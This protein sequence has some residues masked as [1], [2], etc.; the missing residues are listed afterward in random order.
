MAAEL[1]S[2]L[3]DTRRNLFLVGFTILVL[4]LVV[5][6][7][8]TFSIIR[9]SQLNGGSQTLGDATWKID[10]VV[11][12]PKQDG[13]FTLTVQSSIGN[14]RRYAGVKS[15]G[16][17]NDGLTLALSTDSNF[18][19]VNLPTDEARDITFSFSYGGDIGEAIAWSP[20]D[21]EV[22]MIVSKTSGGNLPVLIVIDV[23]SGA[24][25]AEATD[26]FYYEEVAGQRRYV[27]ARFSPTAKLILT[28][29]FEDKDKP[30]GLDPV[31]L[32][33]YNLA[34][35]LRKEIPVRDTI[36]KADQI[37]YTWSRDGEKVLFS[38]NSIGTKINYAQEY[39]FTQVFVG[40]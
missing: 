36:S 10:S 16:I 34:G 8:L 1:K 5:A 9:W 20:E 22:A 13:T 38:A 19:F 15:Y 32:K 21:E 14:I 23:E 6:L 26:S 33:V 11:P 17:S 28:R 39:Q 27:P 31:N 29:T 2:Q 7:S 30:A 12:S 4:V 40:F 25:I 18:R 37:T 24:V 3:L 35:K